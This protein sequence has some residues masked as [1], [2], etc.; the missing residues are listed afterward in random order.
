[1]FHQLGLFSTRPAIIIC[2]PGHVDKARNAAPMT[3]YTHTVRMPAMPNSRS[4]GRVLSSDTRPLFA[5]QRGLLQTSRPSMTFLSTGVSSLLGSGAVAD[6]C[7][8]DED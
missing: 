6:K 4:L 8:V 2:L 7:A 1:M 5:R 3:A